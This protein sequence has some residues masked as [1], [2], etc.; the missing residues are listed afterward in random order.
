MNEPAGRTLVILA[1]ALNI[2]FFQKNKYKYIYIYRNKDDVGMVNSA[3]IKRAYNEHVR[4]TMV[5]PAGFP[6]GVQSLSTS[7][8]IFER[9]CSSNA[10]ADTL[11]EC[12]AYITYIYICIF[13]NL[14]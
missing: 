10:K 5:A 4:N 8:C 9:M 13:A 3:V 11:R 1:V 7:M 12:L 14:Y 6:R 2:K